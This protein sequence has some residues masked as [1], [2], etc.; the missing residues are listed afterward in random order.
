MDEPK[1]MKPP[2]QRS[3]SNPDRKTM[4]FYLDDLRG[5]LLDSG[6]TMT[7]ENT[8]NK[9]LEDGLKCIK[10]VVA[11]LKEGERYG[12]TAGVDV[13][14]AAGKLGYRKEEWFSRLQTNSRRD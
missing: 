3:S 10:L 4:T 1:I 5:G 2:G 6:K 7:G 12:S 13:R 8:K 14:E 9:T 11:T